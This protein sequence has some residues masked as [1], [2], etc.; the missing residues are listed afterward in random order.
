M[1]LLTD[2]ARDAEEQNLAPEQIEARL[3]D[4]RLWSFLQV[5][6]RNEQR[7]IN[8]LMLLAAILTVYLMINPP[9]AEASQVTIN[10]DVEPAPVDT[11]EIAETVVKKPEVDGFCVV[12]NEDK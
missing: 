12:G 8:Y 6:G 10:V 4:T 7:I 5:L 9:S 11:D 2:V 1:Q 3:H